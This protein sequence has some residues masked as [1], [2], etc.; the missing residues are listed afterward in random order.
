[1]EMQIIPFFFKMFSKNAAF[2]FSHEGV[3]H[4]LVQYDAHRFLNWAIL[5]IEECSSFL[6]VRVIPLPMDTLV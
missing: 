3:F 6:F 2:L 1:M 4:F 5:P